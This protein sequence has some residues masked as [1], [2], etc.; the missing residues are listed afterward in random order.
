MAEHHLDVSAPAERHVL[1]TILLTFRSLYLAVCDD[2][3]VSVCRGTPRQKEEEQPDSAPRPIEPDRQIS[4]LS[5]YLFTMLFLHLSKD[6]TDIFQ[7]TGGGQ[8]LFE[9]PSSAWKVKPLGDKKDL[10]QR[11]KDQSVKDFL[12]EIQNAVKKYP[13]TTAC[14]N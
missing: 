6:N 13:E 4:S 9:A 2:D 8:G 5:P 12:E 7:L 11:H 1:L 3:V 10:V 14:C